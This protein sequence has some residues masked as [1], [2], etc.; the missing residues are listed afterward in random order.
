MYYSHHQKTV[1]V[2][3]AVAFVGGLDMTW[4]RYDNHEH[5]LIDPE[6]RKWLGIDYY[7]PNVRSP[8]AF[9]RIDD[10]NRDGI[11]RSLV[12]RMPWHDVEVMVDSQAAIDVAANFVQRWNHH[13]QSEPLPPLDA[14]TTFADVTGPALFHRLT[15]PEHHQGTLGEPEPEPEG[16]MHVQ[17]LRSL[18]TWSG[19]TSTEASILGAYLKAIESAESFIYIENQFFISSTAG[20]GVVNGIANAI[21]KRIRHAIKA[22]QRFHVVILFPQPEELGRWSLPILQREYRTIATGGNSILDQYVS[23]D[24]LH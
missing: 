23:E 6:R 22:N 12:T 7:N 24:C 17:V 8:A 5:L 20:N 1:I 2:D 21:I 11:D 3:R 19:N 15:R 14:S 16:T 9:F 18:S 10:P 13:I 4:G